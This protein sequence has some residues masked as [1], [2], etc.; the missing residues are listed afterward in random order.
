[1]L[2]IG[3][4]RERNPK[5]PS[6]CKFGFIRSSSS[7]FAFAKERKTGQ[8]SSFPSSVSLAGLSVTHPQIFHN[9]ADSTCN[10]EWSSAGLTNRSQLRFLHC[11]EEQ[12]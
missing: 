3:E 4:G 10:Q 2:E 12:K 1:V 6:L 9:P 8:G 11:P 7:Q 5:I